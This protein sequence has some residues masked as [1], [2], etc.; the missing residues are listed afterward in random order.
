M[1]DFVILLPGFLMLLQLSFY[2]TYIYIY[3]TSYNMLS[4]HYTKYDII[5][6]LRIIIVLFIYVR[7]YVKVILVT[8]MI[9]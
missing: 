8:I 7:I 5:V 4:S 1:K 9:L 3:I 2:Y 6:F